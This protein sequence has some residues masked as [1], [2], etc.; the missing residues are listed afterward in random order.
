[1]VSNDTAVFAPK[2]EVLYDALG[3]K[4]DVPEKKR[5]FTSSELRKQKKDRMARKKKGEDV[6]SDEEENKSSR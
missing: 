2:Q 6:F 4:I 3:N 5:K 1:M